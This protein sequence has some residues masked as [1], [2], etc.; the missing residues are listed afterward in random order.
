LQKKV[1]KI[2]ADLQVFFL[3]FLSK[4]RLFEITRFSMEIDDF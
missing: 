2:C 1:T 3:V 4:S